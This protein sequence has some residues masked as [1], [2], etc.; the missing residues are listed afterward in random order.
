MGYD[1]DKCSAEVLAIV[2]EGETREAVSAGAEAIL[3]LDQTVMYAE[4]GGQV[5]DHGVIEA[6]DFCFEVNNVLKN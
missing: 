5:A 6:G 2:A 3:V 4:M 1:Q